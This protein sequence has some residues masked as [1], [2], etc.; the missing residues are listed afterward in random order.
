MQEWSPTEMADWNAAI[1]TADWFDGLVYG[2]HTAVDLAT[3][4]KTS[5][6][7]FPIRLYPDLTHR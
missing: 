3:F 2:P 6:S 1:A 4:I 7:R 5:P